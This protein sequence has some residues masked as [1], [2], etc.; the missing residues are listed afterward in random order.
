MMKLYS[1][2]ALPN[3]EFKSEFSK[4][5]EMTQRDYYFKSIELSNSPQFP[6]QFIPGI[7]SMNSCLGIDKLKTMKLKII[8]TK[9]FINFLQQFISVDSNVLLEITPDS[10]LIIKS[11]TASRTAVK[12]GSIDMDEIFS[13]TKYQ[14]RMI[15][16]FPCKIKIGIYNLPKVIQ[17]LKKFGKYINDF[18][19]EYKKDTDL[20]YYSKSI[21][22]SGNNI[23]K[24]FPCANKTLFKYMTDKSASS[25]FDE[26]KVFLKFEITKT[27][28]KELIELGKLEP[29]SE[30][31]IQVLEI[32]KSDC[33]TRQ[34]ILLAGK[35][36][37]YYV[38]E[39]IHVR[40]I[41]EP[42]AI[43]KDYLKYLD[44]DDYICK[45]NSASVTFESKDR[46]TKV[47]L[48]RLPA[49]NVEDGYD[50]DISDQ[51]FGAITDYKKTTKK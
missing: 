50:D 30:L 23:Q 37:K 19:I 34:C 27:Q 44:S 25:V 6:S 48:G 28:I 21:L 39:Q 33:R 41:S 17:M 36:F 45:V 12:H 16:S 9:S 40:E 3:K 43:S 49:D 11:Y 2:F 8:S 46:N 5:P 32:K 1:L 14:K 10:K 38:Y 15:K 7:K 26:P 18:T 47:A 51:T 22:F 20:E 29:A 42:A 24:S 35:S 4:L 13:V 31:Q